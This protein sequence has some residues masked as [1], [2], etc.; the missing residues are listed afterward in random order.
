MG[1]NNQLEKTGNNLPQKPTTLQGLLSNDNVKKRFEEM[2]GKKAAGFISS[3]ISAT[4]GNAE[5]AKC[6]PNSII[7]SAV[8]AATLD[9]PIQSNLGFAAIIPYNQKQQDGTWLKVAQFQVMWRGM[10]QLA[11]RSGLYQSMNT[12]EVFE[13]ELVKWSRITG[14]CIIDESKKTSDVVIGYVAHFK[15]NTGF[16]KYFYMTKEECEKHGKKYSKTYQSGFGKWKEDFDGMAKKTVL[17]LLLSK[18]GIM[19]VDIQNALTYDQAV[20]KNP[21]TMEVEYSD[22]T[23][24]GVNVE[25]VEEKSAEEKKKDLKE[26]K[27]KEGEQGKIEM[28]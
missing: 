12:S 9:L 4:K 24:E 23:E 13:G 22:N 19:S 1:E 6:E 27:T 28:P 25:V 17:K 7:S 3:I 20:V 8:I 5:L 11:I 10:V 15:L 16:E 18:F 14:E 2:L 21:E 26:K